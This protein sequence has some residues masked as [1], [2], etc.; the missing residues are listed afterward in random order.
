MKRLI[1]GLALVLGVGQ[2][3]GVSG[4]VQTLYPRP[5]GYARLD[6]DWRYLGA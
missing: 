3:E 6:L 2:V 5:L 4:E 1:I